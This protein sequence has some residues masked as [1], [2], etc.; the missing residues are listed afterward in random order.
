MLGAWDGNGTPSARHWHA[1]STNLVSV[2]PLV[3]VRV[4]DSGVDSESMSLSRGLALQVGRTDTE[5]LGEFAH[6][7]QLQR[8]AGLA[9]A[10]TGFVDAGALAELR[11]A[12][13]G[14]RAP[15][16]RDGTRT[17]LAPANVLPIVVRP[18]K[19]PA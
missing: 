19:C 5:G 17:V 3:T 12:E 18:R 6:G 15:V 16:A 9:A 10:N 7:G 11:L 1:S 2:T 14:L 13:S 8:L 4:T